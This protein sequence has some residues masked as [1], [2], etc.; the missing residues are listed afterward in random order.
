MLLVFFVLVGGIWLMW[1]FDY[2]ISV[3][4]IVGFIVLVGVVVEIGV[5]MLIY[6]DYV[7]EVCVV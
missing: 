5:V 2:N 4:V 3:V 7:F 6:F 1:M